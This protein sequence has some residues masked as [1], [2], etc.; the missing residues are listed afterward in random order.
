MTLNA[1]VVGA[2]VVSGTHLSALERNPQTNLVAICDIDEGRASD[3]ATKYGITAYTD[4]DEMLESEDLDWV[5]ICTSV[6]THV[7]L[8][9]KVIDKGIPVQIEKPITTTLE[10]FRE[11]Q[12]YADERGVRFSE[13]HQHVFDPAMRAVT[14]QMKRGDLGRVRSVEVIFT[15]LTPPDTER[16]G[17]WAFELEGG[18]FEEGLPHPLYLALAT[19]GYPED[20]EAISAVTSLAN[21]YEMDF[22]YDNAAVQ[23][24]TNGGCMVS[25]KMISGA[26]SQRLV[27][28]HGEKRSLMADLVSQTVMK[29][30]HDPTS[31]SLSKVRYNVERS[32]DLIGG[33]VGNASTVLK[34][35]YDDGWETAKQTNPHY[36]QIDLEA[37]AIAT[38]RPMPV[39]VEESMWTMVLLEA[40]REAARQA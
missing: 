25:V 13:V 26:I 33:V 9:K 11:L 10:E 5:H 7:A 2:G 37:K 36:Y 20:E 6:Q 30:S 19:G 4:I 14:Q 18:E 12:E 23:Y 35:K 8:A 32:A 21:E 38:G 34:T 40:V 22:T 28:V 1:A 31:T 3:V 16:R 29:V 39:P 24:R 17:A 27:V 15:G